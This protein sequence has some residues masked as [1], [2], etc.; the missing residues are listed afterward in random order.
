MKLKRRSPVGKAYPESGGDR[1]QQDCAIVH[2]ASIPVRA[3]D[4]M[5]QYY[6]CGNLPHPSVD[7]HWLYE[8]MK[9][10]DKPT[11]DMLP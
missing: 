6:S 7:Q 3:E 8:F 2:F 11:Y 5:Y 10:L 9:N 1:R 4:W